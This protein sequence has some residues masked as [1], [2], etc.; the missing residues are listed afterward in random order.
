VI[1][2]LICRHKDNYLNSPATN[3]KTNKND[4]FIKSKTMNSKTLLTLLTA[5]IATTA[6]SAGDLTDDLTNANGG[7]GGRRGSD[8]SKSFIGV[9]VGAGIP[10]GDYGSI[11]KQ[12]SAAADSNKTKGY[13]STGFHFNVKAGHL[14]SDNVGAMIQIGGNMNGFDK[15]DYL[16]AN[17]LPTSATFTATSYY[18]GSYL[19]GPYVS[20]PIGGKLSFDIRAL[21]G[22]MTAS[23]TQVTNS[24]TNPGF[25]PLIPATTYSDVTKPNLAYCFGYN[26]GAGLKLNM[27]DKMGLAL[28]LDYLG[29]NPTSSG[30]KDTDTIGSSTTNTTVTHKSAMSTGILN[31]SLG[32]IF[33][34]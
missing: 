33:N 7:R 24:G 4:K 12:Y 26:V 27:T 3:N 31:I 30:S 18:I 20:F 29:G 2:T 21:V 8:D 34:L 19:V 11:A 9:S 17:D 25:P 15:A 10:M 14:F 22:L 16:S 5:I 32:L 1:N 6:M 13:A 23:F 28:G